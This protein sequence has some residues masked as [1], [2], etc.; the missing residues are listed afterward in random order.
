MKQITITI[1]NTF[2]N[3]YKLVTVKRIKILIEVSVFNPK[4]ID[5]FVQL[6]L[7]RII[8]NGIDDSIHLVPMFSIL[9]VEYILHN[10]NKFT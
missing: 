9:M 8:K 3:P 7:R 1:E 2:S 6:F 4:G 5:I 10:V